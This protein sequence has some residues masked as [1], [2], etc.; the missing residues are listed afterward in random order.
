MVEGG[1]DLA[2]RSGDV[3][4]QLA[5]TIRETAQ[6]AKVM[7][8]IIASACQKEVA[9]VLPPP[10]FEM[11]PAVGAG[12]PG[13]DAPVPL[14]PVEAVELHRHVRESLPRGAGASRDLVAAL[15]AL[16]HQHQVRQQEV[17]RPKL[18]AVFAE[19][20]AGGGHDEVGAGPGQRRSGVGEVF[21]IIRAGRQL[22]APLSRRLACLGRTVPAPSLDVWGKTVCLKLPD[23]GEVTWGG[24]DNESQP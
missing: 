1:V 7:G 10:L 5:D 21:S 4:A 11:H 22:D 24:C 3:I 13:R 2:Q 17:Q 14:A 23:A 8:Q 19:V 6:A 9:I 18:V 20:L 12:A 16:A 15:G